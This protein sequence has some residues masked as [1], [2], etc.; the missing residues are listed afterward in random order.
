MFLVLLNYFWLSFDPRDTAEQY[1]DQHCFK[2]HSEVISSVWNAVLE[3]APWVEPLA[4]EAQVPK[5]YRIGTRHRKHPLSKWAGLS[6]ANC[7]T[8]LINARAIL[9]E[10]QKRTG[11][12]HTAWQDWEFLWGILPQVKFDLPGEAP[13]KLK[14]FRP[15]PWIWFDHANV[16]PRLEEDYFTVPP[17]CFGQFQV[18]PGLG[19]VGAY[20][21]YYLDKTQTIKGGMRYY[22]GT[23]VPKWL[24]GK[25][26]KTR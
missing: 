15:V 16:D 22:H 13:G 14:I 11:R 21:E 3:A 12:H 1:C 18:T 10:H 7:Y 4:D 17:R 5:S 6:A 19:V 26:I 23:E 25:G 24:R 2:I 9:E 20:R 8:S